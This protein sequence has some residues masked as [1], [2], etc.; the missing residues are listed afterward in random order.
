MGQKLEAAGW[1]NSKGKPVANA[2]IW[3]LILAGMQGREI[4]ID[5]REGSEYR[6]WLAG[7]MGKVEILP[8]RS[9]IIPPE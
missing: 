1:I 9:K 3:K 2:D 6:E 8:G 7:E 4:R 5:L